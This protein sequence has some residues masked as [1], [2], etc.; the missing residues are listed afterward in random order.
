MR[1][2]TLEEHFATPSFLDGPGQDLKNAALK[3]EGRA[4]RLIEQLTDIADKRIAAMDSAGIDM[5]VL[6][7]TSPGT[8]QLDA[9]DA[10]ALSREVNDFLAAGVKKNPKRFAG[11]ATLPTAAPDKAAAELESRMKS[12]G[13]VGAVIN[14]HNRGRYLDDKFFWPILE[15]AEALN[16]PIHLHPTRP[17]QPVVDAYYS[18]FSPLLDDMFA[19]PGWGWHI[20]TAVH[21]IRV[22][23]GGTFDRF[24]KLQL[25]IG[26]LGEGLMSMFQRLEVMTPAMTKLK[27][28]V[29]SYLRE[30]VHYTFS[31]F[32]FPATF[33][34]LL[35]EVGVDRIMFSADHPYQLMA[36]VVAFL[37]QTPVSVADRERIAHGNA[38]K[39][40]GL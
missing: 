4:T 34:D 23:L 21:V 25:V 19:S 36:P 26:H 7:L 28:P 27:K 2:I 35:L 30:N 12:D 15:A 11:F 22:V 17:P 40:L 24:P 9:G 1:I 33:L 13:F 39:L 20:E 14:G 32:N 10:V 31:G 8:E 18:G 3:F 37:Q 38:E 5:Q 16:A 6:S 29:T